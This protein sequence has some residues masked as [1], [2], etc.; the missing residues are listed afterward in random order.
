MNQ[1]QL[2][3]NEIPE[4]I[5]YFIGA[6][7]A[8]FLISVLFCFVTAWAWNNFMPH[9]FNL[10]EITIQQ[11]FSLNVLQGLLMFRPRK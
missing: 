6:F 8:V 5:G 10:P 4:A 11:A 3:K 1:N 7:I 9:A 2:K